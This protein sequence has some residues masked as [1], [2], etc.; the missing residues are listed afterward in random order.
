M[1]RLSIFD[2]HYMTVLIQKNGIYKKAFVFEIKTTG[3]KK[4]LFLYLSIIIDLT[5]FATIIFIYSYL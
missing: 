2:T 5:E 3:E 1:V 4:H